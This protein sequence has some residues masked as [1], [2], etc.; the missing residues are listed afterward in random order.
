[1]T[2]TALSLIDFLSV[3]RLLLAIDALTGRLL[4]RIRNLNEKKRD[5][6]P[7]QKVLGE[8]K[9]EAASAKVSENVV[10]ITAVRS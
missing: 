3:G 9:G 1:M 4:I 7:H 8:R 6:S 10:S 2:G 5:Q